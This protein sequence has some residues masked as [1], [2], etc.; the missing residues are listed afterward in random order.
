MPI[1]PP[2]QITLPSKLARAAAEL[3][4]VEGAV[5][6]GKLA[7]DLTAAGACVECA[8]SLLQGLSCNQFAERKSAAGDS[9]HVLENACA[10]N[11]P[12]MGWPS[13]VSSVDVA[14]AR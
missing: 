12:Q 6:V 10:T 9:V 11:K 13:V 14:I 3:D 2:T 5:T 1:L 7:Q 4:A 8:G